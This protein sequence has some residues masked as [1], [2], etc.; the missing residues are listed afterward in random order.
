MS[1]AKFLS[2]VFGALIAFSVL[3]YFWRPQAGPSDKVPLVWVSDNNPARAAQ[4]SAFN[5]ENPSLFLS[6]DYGN[7][8]LQ[9]II[10]QCASGVGPDIF[11]YSSE[12]IETYVAAGV[13]MDVTEEADKSGFSATKNLWPSGVNTITVNGHQY[14]YPCNIGTNILVYNKNVFDYFGVPYPEGILTWDQFLE[15]AQ[16]VSTIANPQ[17]GKRPVFGATGLGWRPVFES[18]RGEYFGEKGDLQI[19]NSNDLKIAF[20]MH[21]D[22][23]FKY[24]IMASSV[25]TKSMGSQGG[26]GGGNLNQ[27]ASGRFAMVITGHWSLIAFT[28]AY[29]QSID[30]LKARGINPD[31]VTD[32]FERPLRIGAVLIP[33]FADMPPYYRLNARVAGI[34][35]KSPRREEALKF[36]QY[37]A[38]PTYSRLL[39][40]GTDWLPGNPEYASLGVEP[41][42]E[43]LN[44]VNLQK[45][46]EEAVSHGY[47]MRLS[48]YLLTSDV[49]RVIGAQVS[50]LESNPD[51]SIDSLLQSADSELKK[52]IR[53]NLDRNQELKE[54]YVKSFGEA[55]Y[56]Q[57]P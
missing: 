18:R 35:S 6:L 53:R 30:N 36:L 37:L 12:D 11:D 52:L 15:L 54:Q 16:K 43:S 4:I 2:L 5:E 50:R 31:E 27:F 10:L 34:N 13:L 57:L 19:L 22:Y 26:W 48:P 17:P 9:K 46:T 44:R 29:K 7:S 41:G 45:A 1:T 32:P 14:G 21:K 55:A 20:Q 28:Q 25:E 33:K 23:L 49:T 47:S 39:N 42:P 56:Q 8:G 3:A 38:G 24:R 40:E 51:I